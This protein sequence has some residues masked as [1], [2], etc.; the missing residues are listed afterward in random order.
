MKCPNCGKTIKDNSLFCPFCGKM[1]SIIYKSGDDEPILQCHTIIP[2]RFISAA[3][4]FLAV[5]GCANIILWFVKTMVLRL[6]T[7]EQE[8]DVQFSLSTLYRNFT[9]TVIIL[10]MAAMTVRVLA[11][12][13]GKN[14]DK[15]LYFLSIAA[16][17]CSLSCLFWKF[18]T[19]ASNDVGETTVQG[20]VSLTAAGWT[21]VA[22][23]LL[24]L[25]IHMTLIF[26]R[27]SQPE[28]QRDS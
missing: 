14:F 5:L 25:G 21:L 24:S 15:R 2:N 11:A 9:V 10:C 7:A 17:V 20:S 18:A 1:P 12:I 23:C 26:A 27:K 3:P 13:K 16:D 22:V 19:M 6:F 8:Y 28:K 4:I